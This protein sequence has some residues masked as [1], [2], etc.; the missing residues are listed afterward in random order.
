MAHFDADSE[1]VERLKK[2]GWKKESPLDM[3]LTGADHEFSPEVLAEVERLCS[4]NTESQG[5]EE[6]SPTDK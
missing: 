2:L 3:D 5:S 6:S 1:T 4:L